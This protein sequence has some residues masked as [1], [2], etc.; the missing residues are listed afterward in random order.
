MA[1]K[2]LV[3]LGSGGYA[4]EVKRILDHLDPADEFVYLTP[5]HA[6]T[7]ADLRVHAGPCH[8][9]PQFSTFT[10]RGRQRDVIAF[11]RTFFQ[12]IKIIRHYN[13]EIVLCVA[14]RH[15]IP[16]LMAARLLGCRT[17]FVESLTRVNQ[18]S[19]TAKIIYRFNFAKEFYVQWPKLQKFF[20]KAQVAT[21]I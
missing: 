16:I 11:V 7:P 21:I 19:N 2:F 14:I 13:S 12:T 17:I 1:R 18:P 8:F 4:S 6:K 20:P 10:R 9:I 5:L 3:P 15:S